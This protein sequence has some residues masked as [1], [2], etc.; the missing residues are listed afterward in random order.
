MEVWNGGVLGQGQGGRK[1]GDQASLI[2]RPYIYVKV[3]AHAVSVLRQKDDDELL[4]YLLQLVQVRG[5]RGGG[6]MPTSCVTLAFLSPIRRCVTS[7]RTVA[8]RPSSSL[9]G[10]RPT[11][12]AP[13]C[14]IGGSYNIDGGGRPLVCRH[15]AM[16][17]ATE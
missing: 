15:A 2:Y 14:C 12:N 5:R 4:Y 3:R 13:L 9:S 10:P 7:P 1:I 8:P 16:A 6:G 11:P 17:G